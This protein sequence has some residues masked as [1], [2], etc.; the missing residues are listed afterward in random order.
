M[1]RIGIMTVAALVCGVS[2]AHAQELASSFDQLR[3]LV[4]AGDRLT[5]TGSNGQITRGQLV[6]LSGTTLALETDAG[7]RTWSQDVVASILRR[8]PDSLGNGAKIG[9]GIG[10]G[11]GALIGFA[12]ADAFGSAGAVPGVI[13]I[14]GAMGTGIGVWIDG[15]RKS[16]QLVFSRPVTQSGRLSVR[17][18]G[19][20]G[21][22]GVQVSLA[23]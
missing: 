2:P 5:I 19:G 1:R 15:A 9:F 8:Q 18:I 22:G 3:V 10:A 16:D 20:R 6:S 17:P 7:T 13:L 14:Y 4:K 23:F 11:F 12:M 21:T